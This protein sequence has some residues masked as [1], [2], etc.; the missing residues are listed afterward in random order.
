MNRSVPSTGSARMRRRD[1]AGERAEVFA[2][3]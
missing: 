1:D 3:S 2:L